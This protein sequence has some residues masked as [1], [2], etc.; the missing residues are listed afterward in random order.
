MIIRWQNKTQAHPKQG[1]NLLNGQVK[2]TATKPM[3]M[4]PH[5]A[6]LS[7]SFQVCRFCVC[8]TA[9]SC[10]ECRRLALVRAEMAVLAQRLNKRTARHRLTASLVLLVFQVACRIELARNGFMATA[11]PWQ[12]DW[13]PI[14]WDR[15]PV[16][17]ETQNRQNATFRRL[18]DMP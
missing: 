15:A 18:D 17:R 7:N 11:H 13:L 4:G 2:K 5:H 6:T 8:Q 3:P 10:C 9:A 12:S 1:R 14:V 16:D